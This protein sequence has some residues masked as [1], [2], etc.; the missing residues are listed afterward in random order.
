VLRELNPT[1]A[2]KD[3]LDEQAHAHV[4]ALMWAMSAVLVGG[5]GGYW[6][7]SYVYFSWDIMEPITFFT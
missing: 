5:A 4:S 1:L 6:Y 2:L 3:T 7:L